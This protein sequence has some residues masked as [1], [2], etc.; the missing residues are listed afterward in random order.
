MS[1]RINTTLHSTEALEVAE[2]ARR[3]Y[4]RVATSSDV[5]IASSYS[6]VYKSAQ[7]AFL[8]AI[9]V[10]YPHMDARRIFDLWGDCMESVAYCVQYIRENN[11]YPF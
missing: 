11:R 8:A 10:A 1:R 2:E 5:A 3:Y 7:K 4:F 9:K 6:P